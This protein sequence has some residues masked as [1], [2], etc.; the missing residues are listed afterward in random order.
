MKSEIEKI[1]R[2]TAVYGA[3][4]VVGKL[5]SFVMLP[6]YT[7]FL[8]PADYGVLD[9]LSM[10]IDVIGMIAGIGLAAGVFKFYAEYETAAEKAE[11]VSTAAVAVIGLGVTTSALGILAAPQLTDMVLKEAGRPLYFRLFFLI[12]LCQAAEAIPLLLLR[13]RQQSVRFVM[14]N[15]ARLVAMLSLNIYFVVVLRWGILGVLTSNL[16]V[17]AALATGLTTYLVR[18]VG[19]S[20]SRRKFRELALFGY[21]LVFWSVA[22]FILVFS[23]RYFLNFFMGAAAVGIYSLAYKFAF[24][25]S[26][27]GSAPFRLVWEPQRFEIAKRAD[28][29]EIYRRVFL[30]LNITLGMV[31]LGIALFA[32]DVLRIM[33]DPEFLPARRVVPLVVCAQILF[34]WVAYANLG[35]FLENRTQVLGKIAVASVIAVMLL[36]L[37][38]VPRWGVYGAAAATLTA[39]A[40]RFLLV[41]MGSQ[42][43]YRI[44]YGWQRIGLLYLVF[45]GMYLVRQAFDP[46]PVLVS[47]GVNLA[48]VAGVTAF[49][50]RYVLSGRER[51]FLGR[52]ALRWRRASLAAFSRG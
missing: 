28:A 36:N 40:G 35:L 3:G 5:A 19:T 12:Y 21:P 43:A 13:A 16:I 34:V 45:G 7:R 41:Y 9:L 48:L 23:D 25:L 14:I 32:G 51:A 20:F 33:A 49:I 39:Y 44:D 24:V 17:S 29:Q 6:I 2:H 50:Y 37:G 38:M 26:S 42:R 52:H 46:L 27:F 30:Y 8:T 47:V 22:N 11:V 4:I 10:T 15:V 31:A 18:T 1:G